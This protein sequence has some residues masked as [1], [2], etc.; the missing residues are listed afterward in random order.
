VL[1]ASL[2]Q[3]RLPYEAVTGFVLGVL[4]ALAA[5][6]LIRG[7]ISIDSDRLVLTAG[8]AGAILA[9][10]R[11]RVVLWAASSMVVLGIVVIGYTPV[12]SLL[13]LGLEQKDPLESAPAV[14]AL[15]E[16]GMHERS[17]VTPAQG[18]LTAALQVLRSGYA[19]R[20]VITRVDSGQP[21]L[22]MAQ[23][24]MRR[25]GIEVPIDEVGPV[26][27]TRDEAVAVAHLARQRGWKQVILVTQAY[28]MRRASAAF[29]KAGVRVL[30][31]PCGGGTEER[32]S[33][34]R[35][36]ARLAAFRMWSHE[37]IG[38]Q[39]YRWRGWI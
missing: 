6:H 25:T 15:A 14:V 10:L 33:H 27:T 23:Q 22:A 12:V 3:S 36:D 28:H 30:R 13:L 31:H 37:A 29:E 18:R 20:L 9:V 7:V 17:I 34:R 2:A 5:P 8:V 4:L 16:S 39:I 32:D 35:F 26:R 21:S 38:Y 1:K 24:K 19:P 11:A